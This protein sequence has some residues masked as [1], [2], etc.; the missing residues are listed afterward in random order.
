MQLIA[1]LAAGVRGAEIGSATLVQR[2]TATVA[3]YYRDFEAT[4]QFT[5]SPITLDS[6]GSTVLYVDQLVDVVV[7]NSDGVTVREFVAGDAASSV[8][9][10]SRSFTGTSYTDGTTGAS[11]PTN[12]ATVMDKWYASAGTTDWKVLFN[13]VPTN[14]SSAFSSTFFNVV[15]YGAV[16]N[17]VADDRSAIVAAQAAATAVVGGIVFF[18]PG[19]YRITSAI[20]LAASVTWLGGGGKS[21]KIAIDSAVGAG[22]LTLPGN[23]IGATSKVSGIWFGAINGVAPGTLVSGSAASS[24]EFDFED[25]LFGIDALCINPCYA[26]AGTVSALKVSFTRC[27]MRTVAGASQL[28]AQLGAGRLTM[29]D[30][31]IITVQGTCVS[32]VQCDDGAVFDGNR[33]DASACTVAFTRYITMAPTSYGAVLLTNNQFAANFTIACTAIFNTL[34][35]PNRDCLESGNTFGDMTQTPNGCTPYEYVTDGYATI[36]AGNFET[37]GHMTRYSR[38]EN[39]N[40]AAAAGQSV[41]PKAYGTT[42]IY[43][44]VGAALAVNATKGSMGDRW[45]LHVFNATGGALTVNPGTN[46]IF[47]PAIAAP[48]VNPAGFLEMQLQWL[49]DAAGLATWRLVGKF[50]VS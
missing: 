30:C 10:I 31:D 46:V 20:S 15:A 22:S 25:C 50:V 42:S 40:P 13:G 17:G 24:G 44:T 5:T 27:Y 16:G 9:V 8:E 49:P 26:A 45:T 12:L 41:N 37:G 39:Y 33:F 19:T 18:P 29:R 48:V 36:G 28:V 43:R 7:R 23:A 32:L 11:K 1:P 38:Q 47:D 3:V 34:A 6:N 4:Q 14:L 2:G 21:S 35:A